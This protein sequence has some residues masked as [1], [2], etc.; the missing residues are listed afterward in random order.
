ML[1]LSYTYSRCRRAISLRHIGQRLRR[2][3]QAAQQGRDGVKDCMQCTARSS[4]GE[5][6]TVLRSRAGTPAPPPRTCSGGTCSNDR[7]APPQ[8]TP[9][10]SGNN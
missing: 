8:P 6:H 5:V 1:S 9:D 3:L 2:R 4:E 10:R 7:R